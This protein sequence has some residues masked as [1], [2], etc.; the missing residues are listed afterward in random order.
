MVILVTSISKTQLMIKML[1]LRPII[2]LVEL[3]ITSV[4]T[5]PLVRLFSTTM[6]MRRLRKS[7]G[8]DVTGNI[9]V[10]GTVDGRDVA[11]DGALAASA[12]Q[13]GD[14][15]STL[16]N[17]AGYL[18]AGSVDAD[19]LD[20]IDSTSFLRSDADTKTSGDLGFGDNVKAT[21]GTSNPLEIYH[22]GTSSYIDK[23]TPGQ[24]LRLVEWRYR[25]TNPI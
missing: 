22:D 13:P 16:V 3:M 4:S 21:F 19:T 14:N 11:A 17:D 8:I 9:T 7:T 10:S 15:V 25:C 12:V 18:T 2:L 23:T 1:S 24:Y 6:V 20:G 5:V